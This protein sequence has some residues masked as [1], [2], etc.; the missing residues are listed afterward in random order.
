V[1]HQKR[2]DLLDA[3]DELERCGLVVAESALVQSRHELL[4]RAALKRL[5]ELSRK[6]LHRHTALSLEQEAEPSMQWAC[7]D[8]WLLAGERDRALTHLR[9]CARHALENG[10]PKEAEE[11]LERAIRIAETRDERHEIMREQA[12]AH[13]E[14]GSWGKMVPLLRLRRQEMESGQVV[15]HDESEL[16]EVHALSRQAQVPRTELLSRLR[17]CVTS[18]LADPEHRVSAAL[19]TVIIADNSVMAEDAHYAY[20][21][22]RQILSEGH[23]N[24]HDR[25]SLESVYHVAFGDIDIAEAAASENIAISR[26]GASTQYAKSLR[27]GGRVY[28]VC[29]KLTE[30]YAAFIT[31][32]DIAKRSGL[33]YNSYWTLASLVWAALSDGDV[34]QASRW[35]AELEELATT[36]PELRA[37]AAGITSHV[38]LRRGEPRIAEQMLSQDKAAFSTASDD[39]PAIQFLARQIACQNELYGGP[40]DSSLSQLRSCFIKARSSIGFEFAAGVLGDALT[41][42]GRP[43]EAWT[44]IDSYMRHYRRERYP[45]PAFLSRWIG[46]GSTTC[47]APP[48]SA[49]SV[50]RVV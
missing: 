40:S 20:G 16:L 13:R 48:T 24:P 4:S 34:A 17:D 15:V 18:P 37:S 27:F 46:C 45:N 38:A 39:R 3:L 12:L 32:L 6:L 14:I 10:I 43:D 47:E 11:L 30:S 36:I 26:R 5:S 41:L 35:C 21:S 28:R 7:A 29:G 31:A 50:E 49:C 9:N 25:L 8:H 33:L 44:S 1:L 42:R 2:V 19:L 23:I 22:V